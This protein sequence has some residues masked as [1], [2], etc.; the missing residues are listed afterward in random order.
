VLEQRIRP[1]HERFTVCSAAGRGRASCSKA[2]KESEG[3]TQHLE[4]LG[5]DVGVTEPNDAAIYATRSRAG[6][7]RRPGWGR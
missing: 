1:Q 5:H 4:A 2:P 3:V 7:P 6:S